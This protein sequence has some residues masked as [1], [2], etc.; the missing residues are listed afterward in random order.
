METIEFARSDP[1]WPRVLVEDGA[2]TLE[3]VG[4]ADALHD[5]RRF[6]LPLRDAHLA[7]LR[8]DRS[9]HLLL[10]SALLPLCDDAGT[11]GPLD[12]DA[13]RSLL[14]PILLGSPEQVDAFFRMIRR[15]RGV[16]VAHGADPDLLDDGQALAATA[17]VREAPNW[18]R[19]QEDEAA[20][21]RRQR[22]VRLSALDTAVLTYTGQLL[23]ASTVPR[24]DP[25]AVDPGLLAA[26]LDVIAT[27]DGAA[28]GRPLLRDPRR[29]R[30]GVDREAWDEMTSTV[31]AALRRV[32]PGLS[33]DAVRSV[34][35]LM[36]S[37]ATDRGRRQPFD[38]E[39]AAPRAGAGGRPLTFTDD[40]EVARTWTPGDDLSAAEA[41]W[42]FVAE[43][44]GADDEVFTLEDEHVGEGIQL[45]FSADS[46]ARVRMVTG[47]VPG[48]ETQYRVE[49]GLV[50]GLA[51]DRAIVRAY[52]DGGFAALE[53]LVRW[54][55]DPAELEERRRRR[56]G[57]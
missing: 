38:P 5:P 49:Y 6:R 39:A 17:D 35:F 14:D 22:G 46:V 27:A 41:F 20:R 10:W 44:A 32:H 30:T 18:H 1:F 45:H 57:R 12:E 2:L 52:I 13:G 53:D 7:V 47:A 23:H 8:Q 43:R 54:T 33:R 9:R 31:E 15:H 51:H 16:L 50:D 25:D 4:G 3:V 21:R 29:G 40:Q 36:C 28:A 19:A 48:A 11:G 55:P 24:R 37:E 26:V 56:A 42:S 34:S